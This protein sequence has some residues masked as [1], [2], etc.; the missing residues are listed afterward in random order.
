MSHLK[1]IYFFP[2][3]KGI[4]GTTILGLNPSLLQ[5]VGWY[6]NLNSNTENGRDLIK[7]KK[8]NLQFILNFVDKAC[9]VK[10]ASRL[11][12]LFFFPPFFQCHFVECLMS[13]RFWPP[14]YA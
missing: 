7:K 14:N 9:Y 5:L 12:F 1:F 11:L 10:Q 13:H 2:I 6:K 4:I 3:K 8:K